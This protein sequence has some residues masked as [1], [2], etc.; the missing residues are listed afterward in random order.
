M[1]EEPA[2]RLCPPSRPTED[3]PQLRVK[4]EQLMVGLR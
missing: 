4:K 1:G 2:W 3:A